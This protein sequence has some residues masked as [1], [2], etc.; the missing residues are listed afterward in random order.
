MPAAPT[1]ESCGD[2]EDQ[3]REKRTG[4]IL[5]RILRTLG[6]AGGLG[7]VQVR[8]LWGN[9]YRVNVLG[10][11]DS[12]CVK[13]ATSYFVKTDGEGNITESTPLLTKP[14]LV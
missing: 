8:P 2:N 12:G 6:P 5:S 10:A 11:E 9:Y 14:D 3:G 4:V 1:D 13:I 7:R